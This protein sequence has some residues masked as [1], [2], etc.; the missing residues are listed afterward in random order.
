MHL[1]K[2][3]EIQYK[4]VNEIRSVAN[5]SYLQIRQQWFSQCLFDLQNA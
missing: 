3:K 4:L 2:P 5:V 1:I